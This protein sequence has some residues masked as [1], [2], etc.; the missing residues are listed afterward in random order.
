MDFPEIVVSSKNYSKNAIRRFTDP[1]ISLCSKEVLINR[2]LLQSF[3]DQ[4][5]RWWVTYLPV[6][7]HVTSRCSVVECSV[8]ECS[9]KDDYA[10][11]ADSHHYISSGLFLKEK[12][13]LPHPHR[14]PWNHQ[15]IINIIMRST[16]AVAFP[17]I[18]LV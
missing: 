12:T 16:M 7:C 9:A 10:R 1:I 11:G 5:R 2:L 17:S 4:V 13:P 6:Q 14:V 18:I 15:P 8:A 3:T